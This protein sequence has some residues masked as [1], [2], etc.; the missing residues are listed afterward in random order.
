MNNQRKEFL[1]RDLERRTSTLPKLE[2]L[3]E[4]ARGTVKEAEEE[5]SN[6]LFMLQSK[7][8]ELEFATADEKDDIEDDLSLFEGRKKF[9]EE[10]KQKSVENYNSTL[11]IYNRNQEKIEE[12]GNE[13]QLGLS[14]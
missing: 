11:S 1:Q 7:T 9:L 13:L 4:D 5:L 6:M 12:I 3:L 8:E 14:S 10:K 2:K